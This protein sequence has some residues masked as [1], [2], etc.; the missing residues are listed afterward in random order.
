MGSP[1]PAETSLPM[2]LGLQDSDDRERCERQFANAKRELGA[3]AMA[4]RMLYGEAEAARATEHWI[5]LAESPKTPLIDGY[6]NWRHVTIA[7]ASELA[8]A[9]FRDHL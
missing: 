6:P 4:V 8:N 9:R 7:A 3:F 2:A 1:Q 5:E